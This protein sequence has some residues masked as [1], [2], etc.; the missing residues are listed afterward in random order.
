MKFTPKTKEELQKEAFEARG[1]LPDGIYDFEVSTA[2]ETVSKAGN[3]ML[4]IKLLIW[5]MNGHARVIYDYLL[6]D[7]QYKIFNFCAAIKNSE[8]YDAGEV[9]AENLVGKSGKA[10]IV[11]QK[12]KSGQYGDRNVVKEYVLPGA[13]SMSAQERKSSPDDSVRPLSIDDEIPF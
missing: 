1:I 4:K 13:V 8:A 5:D 7:M 9:V 12:D 11:T 6:I 10:R 3:A 2:E